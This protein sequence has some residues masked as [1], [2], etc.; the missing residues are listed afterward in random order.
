MPLATNPIQK[1]GFL[2]ARAAEKRLAPIR[3]ESGNMQDAIRQASAKL[4]G[5]IVEITVETEKNG[6]QTI[7]I[8]F[9]GKISSTI[10]QKIPLKIISFSEARAWA[11][12]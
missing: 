8:R 4:A 11:P 7:M 2:Q 12:G 3:G 9:H 10:H 1:P 5:T 6:Q